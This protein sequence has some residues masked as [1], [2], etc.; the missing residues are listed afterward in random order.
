MYGRVEN[1]LTSV[2]EGD[3]SSWYQKPEDLGNSAGQKVENVLSPVGKHAGPVLENAG[4]P[5]GGVLGPTA[6][7]VMNFGKGWGHEMGVGFGN[8]EGGPAKQQEAEAQ[9][10]KEPFGGKEQN[11]DNPLG[12]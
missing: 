11:A 8:E 6:G 7:A 4:K 2:V 12:L 9:K 1:V 5:L 10:L 3:S